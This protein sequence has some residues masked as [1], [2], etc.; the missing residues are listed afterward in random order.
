MNVK[1]LGCLIIFWLYGSGC[2]HTPLPCSSVNWVDRVEDHWLVVSSS[3]GESQTLP[4]EPR[5]THWREGDAIVDGQIERACQARLLTEVRAL[6]RALT[7]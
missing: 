2:A 4:R 1:H 6:R 7:H 5:R 3:H